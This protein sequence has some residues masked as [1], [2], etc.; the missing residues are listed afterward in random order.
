MGGKSQKGK[1][2]SNCEITVQ[3]LSADV[4][5]KAQKYAW[6]GPREF[7]QLDDDDDDDDEELYKPELTID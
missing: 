3:R 6:I 2:V 7:V 1:D 5:G 4:S